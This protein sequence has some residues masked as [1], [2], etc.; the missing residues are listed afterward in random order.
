MHMN[1]PAWLQPAFSNTQHH[2]DEVLFQSQ[3]KLR[4]LFKS[5]VVTDRAD[6]CDAQNPAY[7][8]VYYRRRHQA[9]PTAMHRFERD[10]FVK[11]PRWFKLLHI[12]QRLSVTYLTTDMALEVVEKNVAHPIRDRIRTVEKVGDRSYDE[13]DAVV[14]HA[15]RRRSKLAQVAGDAAGFMVS[16]LRRAWETILGHFSVGQWPLSRRAVVGERR[17]QALLIQGHELQVMDSH[18]VSCVD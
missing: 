15:R 14:G 17:W 2:A 3:S 4:G 10:G 6:I 18:F 1:Q 9:I 12:N 8:K 16:F 11:K 7:S 13:I 5:G